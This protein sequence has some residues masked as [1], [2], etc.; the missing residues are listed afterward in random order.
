VQVEIAASFRLLRGIELAPLFWPTMRETTGACA[1]VLLS[2]LGSL[3]R[4]P[5]VY[6]FSHVPT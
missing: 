5:K 4:E 3:A 1:L 6:Q 2:L